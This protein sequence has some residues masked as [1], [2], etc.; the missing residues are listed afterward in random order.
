MNVSRWHTGQTFSN[1]CDRYLSRTLKAVRFNVQDGVPRNGFNLMSKTT[2][3]NH[4]AV[5][6][7]TACGVQVAMSRA[8]NDTSAPPSLKRL[9]N[10]AATR[11]SQMHTFHRHRAT[12]PCLMYHRVEG[13][14][15]PP[16]A[17]HRMSASVS[18][19]ISRLSL[20]TG[21]HPR[22]SLS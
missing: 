11:I 14:G 9:T 1:A 22:H 7:S 13:I 20:V 16:R 3:K 15:P 6:F 21:Y 18:D 8:R 4:Q 17:G 19:W 2:K 10:T 5:V 12:L